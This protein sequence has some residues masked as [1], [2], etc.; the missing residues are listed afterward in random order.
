MP[1]EIIFHLSYLYYGKTLG[2]RKQ[3]KK[4]SK[5]IAL[6]MAILLLV[7]ATVPSF[8]SEINNQND[9]ST[10]T[11]SDIAATTL[12]FDNME[13]DAASGYL[14][15]HV[16]SSDGFKDGTEGTVSV[17]KNFDVNSCITSIKNWT[18]IERS[19]SSDYTSAFQ[20]QIKDKDKENVSLKN[21]DITVAG[22]SPMSDKKVV[23][24]EMS[25][26]T[27]KQ[28]DCDND[29]LADLTVQVREEI[30]GRFFVVW[31]TEN[32]SDPDVLKMQEE[33]SPEVAAIISDTETDDI[34]ET[35]EALEAY[36]IL[37]S[38][39]DLIFQRGNV[40]DESKGDVL[41]VFSGFEDS[42]GYAAKDDNGKEYAT[43]PWL[44]S[45]YASKIKNIE[46]KDVIRPRTLAWWFGEST[47]GEQNGYANLTN[48]KSADL[49]N[50]DISR[51]TSLYCTFQNCR[52]LKTL[53]ISGWNT[54]NISNMNST[55]NN[56]TSLEM[57]DTGG[58]NTSS[59]ST[60]TCTFQN[61]SSL[62][63][64]ETS[65][66]DL[67][68]ATIM[69][70]TFNGC[71]NLSVLNTTN[72]N[73]KKILNMSL[74]FQNCSSLQVI[75]GNGWDV[76]NCFN[77]TYIFNGCSS[78][79]E[80]YIEN[81]DP[82][83]VPLMNFMFQ[84]CTSLKKLDLSKWSNTGKV[85]N[86]Y[87]MF[88]NCKSLE[89]LDIS[90]FNTTKVTSIS[91]TFQGCSS[92]KELQLGSWDVSGIGSMNSTFA[93]C[94]S[95]KIL[96][97]ENWNTKKATIMKNFLK[98]CSDLRMITV[99]SNTVFLE[100]AAIPEGIWKCS[101]D[102]QNYTSNELYD[103]GMDAVFYR[104][105][106][107][108]FQANGGIGSKKITIYADDI[109]FHDTQVEHPIRP[110]Y[111]F[112]GWYTKRSGGEKLEENG[113]IT[114]NTYY[115]HWKNNRYKLILKNNDPNA[116]TSGDNEKSIVIE[117]KYDDFYT[118]TDDIFH[119][120][121]Y[122]LSGWNT[123]RNG[124][125]TSY[126]AVCAVCNLAGEEEDEVV[127]YA[128]WRPTTDYA[129]VSF[130][131]GNGEVKD[132]IRI[133][134][135]KAIGELSEP[136]KKGY[137]FL[138]W[139]TEN[140]VHVTEK[141][142]ITEDCKLVVAWGKD[143]VLTF[144]GG[145]YGSTTKTVA[146]N[147]KIGSMPKY[148]SN[149]DRYQ[150]MI[151]WF[152]EDG[153]QVTSDTVV[154]SD[155][156]YYA[157]W[158]W[159]PKFNAAGG[160]I[161]NEQEYLIQDAP[162]YTLMT[163]PEAEKDGY[164]F[165]GW[166]HNGTKIEE[167]HTVDLSNG[168]EL[169]AK[170]RRKDTAKI[171]LDLNGGEY[172][173][174]KVIVLEKSAAITGVYIPSKKEADFLGWADE[175]GRYYKNGDL[176]EKDIKL[177]AKWGKRE[178]TVTFDPG[179]GKMGNTSLKVRKST[180][181]NV[182]PG[183][184]RNGYI[185]QGWYTKKNGQGE[186]LTKETVITGNVTYY[187]F[188]EQVIKTYTKGDYTYTFGAEW[189]NASNADVENVNDAL[190]FHPSNNN[191]QTA[192]LH[193]R[194]ELNKA[195]GEKKL[196]A[197][198]VK[199]RIPKYIWQDW[200][201][202][203][204]GTN[205]ISANLP[206][207]P[208]KRNG[209][210]FSYI[211]D[212]DDYILINNED[213]AGGTGI[214]FT[215]SYRVTPSEVPGGAS[216]ASG[217]YLD[218]YE[219][220]KRTVKI[221]ASVD[222]GGG[223]V[224]TESR[225]LT[226]EMHTKVFPEANLSY[227]DVY[228]RW[229]ENWGA[230][231]ADADDY[232]Y[233][234]WK[235][236][237]YY[238]A[239]QTQ[240]YSYY[241][242]E[243]TDHEGTVVN[244]DTKTK[245]GSGEKTDYVF[246]T[247]KY[248]NE[249]LKDMTSSGVKLTN[250][251]ILN[252]TWKSGYEM[253][254]AVSAE[255]IIYNYTGKDGDFSKNNTVG[256]VRT[257][258]AAQEDLVYDKKDISLKWKLVY[259][260]D[261]NNITWNED[262]LDYEAKERTVEVTDGDP[263]D[264]MY[265]SGAAKA[266]YVWEPETENHILSDDDY[267][268][269]A[270]NITLEEYDSKCIDGKWTDKYEHYNSSDYKGFRIY[271]RYKGQKEYEYYKYITGTNIDIT[272][273]DNVVGYK[274]QH[275]TS[276][277]GTK[278]QVTGTFK[279]RSTTHTS[280]LIAKDLRDGVTSIIK[281][282]SVCNVWNSDDD[283]KTPYFT[284]TNYT[285]GDN[286][287]NKECYELTKNT[288]YQYVKKFAGK[289]SDVIFDS[290]K[291]T[292]DNCMQISGYTKNTGSGK[293]TPV[294]S[295]IFYDLLP[296]GTTV[297]VST[298]FG[299]P[300]TDNKNAYDQTASYESLKNSKEKLQS[301]LYDVQ[302]EEN[303]EGSGRTMMIIRWTAPE[304]K[305]ITGMHIFY[306]LHNTYGN[307]VDHGTSL[308]NDVAFVNTSKQSAKPDRLYDSKSVM[309]ESTV[310]DD[311]Q[312]EYDGYICYA[313]ASTDYI[314]VSAFSWGFDK[315]VKGQ[316]SEYQNEDETL[317]NEEYTY[318]LTYN[319]SDNATSG[320]IQFFD[321]LEYGVEREGSVMD[322]SDWH[323]TLKSVDVSS[324]AQKLT[325]GSETVHCKPVVYYSTKS[326]ASFTDADYDLANTDTWS[327]QIPKDKSTITAIAVDCSKNEDG[328]E[329]VLKGKQSLSVCIRMTAPDNEEAYGKQAKNTA[330]IYSKKESDPERTSMM[331]DASITLKKEDVELHKTSDPASGTKDAPAEVFKDTS[332][333][334]RLTV[335]NKDETATVHDIVVE[336][337]IS[338]SLLINTDQITVS[339][340]DSSLPAVDSPRVSVNKNGRKLS[341]TIRSLAAGETAV[342]TIPTIVNT[343]TGV[344]TNTS[345]ITTINDTVRDIVSETTYHSPK[346]YKEYLLKIRKADYCGQL[347]G[348]AVLKLSGRSIYDD[349]DIE[350]IIWTTKEGEE[351]FI[352]L[353]PGEYTLEE[354]SAPDGYL[355]AEPISI[356][357]VKDQTITMYDNE[358][359]SIT[360]KKEW[361]DKIHPSSAEFELYQDGKYVKDFTVSA[362]DGW[363][364]V[365]DRL[366]KY[367]N[368][369]MSIY[370]YSIKEKE[371]GYIPTYTYNADRSEVIVLNQL[372]ITA[373]LPDAGKRSIWLLI[374]AV[375]I[376]FTTSLFVK[377]KRS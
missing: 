299:I 351:K 218:G 349:K 228:F 174:D 44:K 280:S 256:S 166:Y 333:N 244:I 141:T 252:T 73:L 249:L 350:P 285:G 259:K 169:T 322:L 360:V 158:G 267:Y 331:S 222:I 287:A 189:S 97:L 212:G 77:M 10:Q 210:Y 122:V 62:K 165:E 184:K 115:A 377:K 204:V 36:A 190:D 270:L 37:Y 94:T 134:K 211:E 136:Q 307:I 301:G 325:S 327:K 68:S 284:S 14:N 354:L 89:Y 52:A 121:G 24:E 321:V 30:T 41:C 241:W 316:G 153:E 80:L 35:K 309:K 105:T 39:G 338:E 126:E 53:N 12:D 46:V 18:S 298:I 29:D 164:I 5:I 375:E 82:K 254:Q 253:K 72:W 347:I 283:S 114:E 163:L 45:E 214:D 264:V 310:Y 33:S 27:W 369:D 371:N 112:T 76:S 1:E 250:Q 113:E 263:G 355:V 205:N 231:P 133:L 223:D 74:M 99:G 300:I 317:P 181:L 7:Q 28:I 143:P 101:V 277:Y 203:W 345:R 289:Q 370:E 246:I 206:K 229:N 34:S 303:Y 88:N 339:F 356:H 341:F 278:F 199:I 15:V 227:N 198:S 54:E 337:E 179:E 79:T 186:K 173:Y 213:L 305:K 56:C 103:A 131:T 127:L 107:V 50:L 171:T 128:K 17:L 196:P 257:I 137:A 202:N 258:A 235:A 328:T 295:G 240:D 162:E 151:G 83:N 314:P 61:C 172:E 230:K 148:P 248:P 106:S 361:K 323:G 71:K 293:S 64:L 178:C 175:T 194:Y 290:N 232:F 146:Y 140:G 268:I 220:A 368:T 58:W 344:I 364:T 251:A 144:N 155:T 294:T 363:T 291:G 275:D 159:T 60:M 96:N 8:A 129:T 353:A 265:S 330:F 66:W 219:F 32:D 208:D 376:V 346:E 273:P 276:F 104:S 195:I 269:S 57:L 87:A 91:Y 138:G 42:Y 255:A 93:G 266:K 320:S 13:Q 243:D 302:F 262:T 3:V 332:I 312:L 168:N 274:V 326:R 237:S 157:H 43:T 296:K 22:F 67:S 59:I 292:Q 348:G 142:I 20:I 311:L 318:R 47:V 367:S 358:D 145:E 282:K 65:G 281:D 315:A 366:P 234:T 110:G 49:R 182:I 98:S 177:T 279:L 271:L 308:E 117:M 200:N 260:G 192:S 123:K 70:G 352:N 11:A 334:Y 209:M 9:N 239:Y 197:G 130:D 109:T 359:V 120:D 81:W 335:S 306:L 19:F 180:T 336:D 201:G 216:N 118:L 147:S 149:G 108:S 102:E 187:A 362:A 69:S 224:I 261:A 85:T 38:N 167:G 156:T 226:A 233:V 90:G 297:D 207:Y 40:P 373:I 221:E 152:T 242:T 372:M 329:F 365:L 48:L 185:L 75:D 139:Y 51:V 374:I 84:G 238:N 161:V 2:R 191:A 225:E 176:I 92:L 170:W 217:A 215:L 313:K 16:V 183:A 100:D 288:T 31:V 26:G 6:V 21:A 319:Q 272:L 154:T 286:P 245:T 193:I 236:E 340:G 342:I 95:L 132:P 63:Q 343:G 119:C 4:Y 25:D 357:F 324:I 150:T 247:L 135:G 188:Y 86:M 55:F 125:G 160:K 78:L 23:Y 304:T 111:V 116:L 124:S